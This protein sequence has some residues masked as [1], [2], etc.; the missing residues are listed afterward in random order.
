MARRRLIGAFCALALVVAACGRDDE[1]ADSSDTAA[2][3]A[4]T[5]AAPAAETTAAAAG[6]S[7]TTAAAGADTTAA[8]A[9]ADPCAGVTLEETEV[10]V[11]ADEI[12]ITVMADT[13]SPLAP[14]LFQAN[15]DAVKA[16]A[17]VVNEEG[18]VGCRKLVVKEW[19]SK[20]DATE[21]KNGLIS[22][23]GDS[24]AMVGNNSLFNPDVSPM[25][26]CVDKAGAATGLPDIAAL[27]N[28]INQQCNATTF[29]IQGVSE[30]CTVREGQRPL[31]AMVGPSKFYLGIEPDLHGVYMVP[32]DL[33]T[34]VQSATYLINGAADAGVVWDAALKISG[35]DEQAAFTPKIAIAKAANATFIYN[36]SN[37]KAM[38]KMRKEAAA[39]G[40]D[41]VTVW[42]CS[43]AC[44]TPTFIA[45]G[46]ADVEGTY[47]W[48]QFIPFEEAD[49]NE[50]ATRYVEAIGADKVTSFGA[51]AWQ[52]AVTFKE[53]VDG[54][55]AEQGPNAITRAAI[56]DALQNGGERTAN[57]YMSPKDLKGFSSCFMIMQ[58]QDGEFVRVYPEAKGEFDCDE[59]NVVTIDIDPAVEAEKIT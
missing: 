34:T 50:E 53:V 2:P 24:V 1:A 48:M 44:Y 9:A 8:A 16:Y 47:V 20:L 26:G 18:G 31:K 15:I 51:Q 29:M 40:L 27:A 58:V 43:L 30:P 23:C 7:D 37:D 46:G 22:A 57:G 12:T 35:R 5:T 33:P 42:G 14:G 49:T 19:D 6:G 13:G 45:E 17:D 39:Q 52:A 21:S 38:I 59:G 10:G 36:G 28:D 11:S 56:L 54:I 25:S 4:E 3:A 41:S 55:V 32:G